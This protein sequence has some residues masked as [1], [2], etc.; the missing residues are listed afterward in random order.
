MLTIFSPGRVNLIGEHTDYNDGFVLPA[1]VDRGLTMYATINGSHEIRLNALDRG[2]SFVCSVEDELPHTTMG[3]T[4]YVLGVIDQMWQ[5]GVPKVG[6]DLTFGGNLPIG[7]GMSSSAALTGG[8]AFCIN[9]LQG[10]G[11]S[12]PELARI[13]QAAEHT[14]VGIRS[15]ILDQFA[16][17]NC[18]AGHAML[19]DCRS[20]DVKQFAFPSD[21]IAIILCDTTIRRELVASEY[22]ARRA[23]CEEAVAMLQQWYPEVNSLRDV[24]LDM[25]LE[26]SDD[27][28]PITWRRANYVVKENDRTQAA[29][30]AL[31]RGDLTTFGALMYQS[32]LGLQHE[33]E[34][35]CTELDIMTELALP[36]P[37]VLGSRMMG[38]GFGGCTINLVQNENV[39]AFAH[40]MQHL[41]LQETG[42]SPNI[43][44]CTLSSG[45]YII[46]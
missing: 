20:L 9:E 42:L 31:E 11:F 14:F 2:E 39:D 32:H 43:H 12:R 19:L 33:Y 25:M 46:D 15:G 4:D 1:A 37:G 24:R 13:A 26:H 21:E 35:S 44:T 10:C 18:I 6:F 40:Q 23:Q 22:N 36:L 3:W 28:D 30:L 34:V 7:A 5:R 17:L 45:T 29:S 38:G 41:Y 8:T 16:S 27:M